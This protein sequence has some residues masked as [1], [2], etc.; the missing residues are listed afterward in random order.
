MIRLI[1]SGSSGYMG[2][3][4]AS[5]VE[6]RNDMEIVAG[7]DVNAVKHF[8]FPVYADP[9]EYSGPAD[10]V[11]D[12]SNPS[13]LPGLLAYCKKRKLAAV[14]ATTGL[15]DSDVALIHEAA[16]DI[17]VFRSANMSLGVSLLSA[18]AKTAAKLL[19][20]F[21]IEII[22]KHHNRKLDAPS[23]TALMLA[24]ALEEAL[25]EK[26]EYVYDRH[27]E[28][29]AR[30]RNEIGIHTVRGGTIVGDHEI[31]FAG[32]DEVIELRHSASSRGVFANGALKAAAFL[33][34]RM[35][36]LYSMNDIISGL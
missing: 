15:S 25:S 10:V 13:A 9:M 1:L 11:I 34:G 24:E 3:T 6:N 33:S 7:F 8:S 12:F 20:S 2:R 21:D 4:I 35:P 5:L 32:N 17:P 31:I 36:G 30:D 14:I 18:L 19:D 23:G 28:R 26:P 29:K 16:R 22:E 27:L